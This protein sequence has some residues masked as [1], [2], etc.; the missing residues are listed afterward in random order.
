VIKKKKLLSVILL[1]LFVAPL[2][3]FS[4]SYLFVV[5]SSPGSTLLDQSG[6]SGAT[7]AVICWSI[8]VFVTSFL[9]SPIHA[10][11]PHYF[12]HSKLVGIVP[13]P[14]AFFAGSIFYLLLSLAVAVLCG[15]F[16]LRDADAC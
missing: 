9:L 4:V 6:E 15:C 8:H 7:L 12:Q 16:S 13:S 5:D 10:L 2:G 11:A 1:L 14:T 3:A